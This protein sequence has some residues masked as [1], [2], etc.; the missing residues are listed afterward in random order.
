MPQDPSTLQNLL[1]QRQAPSNG[2]P[3]PTGEGTDPFMNK[4]LRAVTTGIGLE[5]Q[6]PGD[7][8]GAIGAGIG[9]LAP[10]LSKVFSMFGRTAPKLPANMSAIKDAVSVSPRMREFQPMPEA[11]SLN[12]LSREELNKAIDLTKPGPTLPKDDPMYNAILARAKGPVGG[13]FIN[14]GRAATTSNGTPIANRPFEEDLKDLLSGKL[15]LNE[16]N[17]IAMQKVGP[18]EYGKMLKLGS[19]LERLTTDIYYKNYNKHGK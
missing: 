4:V 18:I 8:A 9:A 5:S 1:L 14:N 12:D 16:F 6:K 17:D 2:T 13:Q 7:T 15:G 10:T 11:G 3:I 19:P